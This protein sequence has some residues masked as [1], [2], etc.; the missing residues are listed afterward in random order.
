MPVITENLWH[1]VPLGQPIVRE[2]AAELKLLQTSEPVFVID[3]KN[4]TVKVTRSWVDLASAER[5]SDF[6]KTQQPGPISTNII[7][8]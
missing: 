8:E 4:H 3:E 7:T 5:W 1:Q 6:V 2:K